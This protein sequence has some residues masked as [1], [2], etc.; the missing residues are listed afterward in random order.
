MDINRQISKELI[1]RT[2]NSIVYN[3]YGSSLWINSESGGDDYF[4]GLSGKLEIKTSNLEKLVY[5]SRILM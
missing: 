4:Y 2:P 5:L 1:I 3:S